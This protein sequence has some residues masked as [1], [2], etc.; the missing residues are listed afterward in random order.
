MIGDII[1][2]DMAHV[3]ITAV[4]DTILTCQYTSP[5]TQIFKNSSM[6]TIS[7]LP[8]QDGTNSLHRFPYLNR[9]ISASPIQ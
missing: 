8:E 3:A 6:E 1:V 4:A 9:A 2:R 7:T 5:Q